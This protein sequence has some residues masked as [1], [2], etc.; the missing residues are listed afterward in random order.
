MIT[1]HFHLI[2]QYKYEL[3]HIYFTWFHCTG[4]N[5]VNKLTLLPMCGF[6]AQ[7]VEHRTGIAEVMG[8]N[9]VE[10]L[11][12]FFFFQASTFQ[13]L[14]VPLTPKFF[15]NCQKSP[16]CSDHI[17]EK[18]IVV[19]FFLNFLWIF[20]IQKIRATAVHGRVTRRMGRVCLWRQP[21]KRFRLKRKRFRLERWWGSEETADQ[22]DG[23][24]ETFTSMPY[25][26]VAANCRNVVDLSKCIFVHNLFLWRL[27]NHFMKV[28]Q[29]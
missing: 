8:S 14:K 13:L 5:K 19:R 23:S 26:C 10:A 4:R 18:I 22:R 1:L 24:E 12:F 3:F 28:Q 16:F 2:P 20:K 27:N 7:L 17:G 25:R 21:G 9:P 6:I 11:S 29:A 15:L